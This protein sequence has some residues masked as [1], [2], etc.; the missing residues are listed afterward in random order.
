MSTVL[1]IIVM[2]LIILLPREVLGEPPSETDSCKGMKLLQARFL[3]DEP[4]RQKDL[5]IAQLELLGHCGTSM[6]GIDLTGRDLSGI[7]LA[8][9]DLTNAELA[10]ANFG[11]PERPADLQKVDLDGANL[12][13]ADLRAADLRGA[14]L[15]HTFL[16]ETK[17]AGANLSGAKM[18][19][20]HAQQ[21]AGEQ[22]LTAAQLAAAC[23]AEQDPP[24]L[25]SSLKDYERPAGA[26]SG[27][28][29]SS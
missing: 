11:G 6:V 15:R 26:P 24:R 8:D 3:L 10:G 1:R 25:P 7:R 21:Q 29:A 22:K 23:W 20:P 12:E 17:F 18:G 4:D 2:I 13:G 9:A 5:T 19:W 16:A 28:P 27:C 14:D